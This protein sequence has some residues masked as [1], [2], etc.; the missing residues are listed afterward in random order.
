MWLSLFAF[1][2]GAAARE[3]AET[4]L[5]AAQLQTEGLRQE[6][7]SSHSH[8]VQTRQELQFC[9]V[10]VDELEQQCQD[11]Q[12]QNHQLS[13]DLQVTMSLLSMFPSRA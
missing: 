10:K 2:Q 1:R 9:Q 6:L 5:A 4:S 7:A 3:E 12:D 11:L 13:S 8:L